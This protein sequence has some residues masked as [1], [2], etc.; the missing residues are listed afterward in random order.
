MRGA[1]LALGTDAQSAKRSR[2]PRGLALGLKHLLDDVE[3][4][5]YGRVPEANASEEVEPVELPPALGACGTLG[6]PPGAPCEE[7]R[8]CKGRLVVD[9]NIVCIACGNRLSAP[10]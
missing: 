7:P 6:S 9:E 5:P 3:S 10:P 2:R 1:L 8:Y 4:D